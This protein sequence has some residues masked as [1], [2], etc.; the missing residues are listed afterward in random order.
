MSI[1]SAVTLAGAMAAQ[2]PA[3]LVARIEALEARNRDLEARLERLVTEQERPAPPPSPIVTASPPPTPGSMSTSTSSRD[4]WDV[5]YVGGQIGRSEVLNHEPYVSD[6]YAYRAP[7]TSAGFV[8]VQFGRRWQSGSWVFGGEVSVSAPIGPS[9][10]EL[11]DVQPPFSSPD[12][13]YHHRRTVAVAASGELGWAL[14]DTLLYSRIGIEAA[15]LRSIGEQVGTITTRTN[16]AAPFFGLGVAHQFNPDW[17][18]EVEGRYGY[19]RQG[20]ME[21][22]FALGLRVNY[23]VP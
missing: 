20:L 16:V 10:S 12:A 4:T 15:Q 18:L 13:F 11:Y 7:E 8:S 1:L 22:N 17:S 9:P 2:D 23:L 19:A 3:S 6:F 21:N 5:S 14:G